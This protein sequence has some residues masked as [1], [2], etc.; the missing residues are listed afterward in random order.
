MWTEKGNRSIL[1]ERGLGR[2]EESKTKN[3]HWKGRHDDNPA[4]DNARMFAAQPDFANQ[5]T[6]PHEAVISEISL[7][8]QVDAHHE[9]CINKSGIVAPS[10]NPP[11]D[12][13]CSQIWAISIKDDE[14]TK[15]NVAT[16]S[17]NALVTSSIRLDTKH[18]PELGPT[19]SKFA[20]NEKHGR[21]VQI[22][23]D[24]ANYHDATKIALNEHATNIQDTDVLQQLRQA[25]SKFK[26]HSTYIL[27]R[28]SSSLCNFHRLQPQTIF[29]YCTFDNGAPDCDGR[30]ASRIFAHVAG[31]VIRKKDDALLE[32]HTII[33]ILNQCKPDGRV[34]KV[35]TDIYALFPH[36]CAS[37]HLLNNGDLS[38]TLREL[39]HILP[40]YLSSA[41]NTIANEIEN[42]F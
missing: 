27:S 37:I 4:E 15:L 3:E 33:D 42:L 9:R 12:S 19:T 11:V 5:K 36:E 26:E 17:F 7:T 2:W 8:S 28:A 29:T 10:T 41:N 32:K 40:S 18:T 16:K 22:F 21:Q 25:R 35:I 14:G 39:A 6:A 23:L 31:E 30:L 13:R 24:T 20:I 34:A 1:E 38:N